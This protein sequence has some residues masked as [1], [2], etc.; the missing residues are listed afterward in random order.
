MNVKTIII[1]VVIVA[2]V[3]GLFATGILDF[4]VIYGKIRQIIFG[5]PR[6]LETGSGPGDLGKAR[7]CRDNLKMIESTKRRYADSKGLTAGAN[8]SWS[9][10]KMTGK[11]KT[12]PKCPEGGSYTLGPVGSLPRCSIGDNDTL[13]TDDDHRLKS[14]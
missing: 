14:Y 7:Q 2:V 11:W 10:I 1:L 3:A 6:A 9:D 13:N 12:L 4:E 5:A 8:V